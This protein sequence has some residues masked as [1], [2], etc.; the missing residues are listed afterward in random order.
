MDIC[1]KFL[2][3]S[4]PLLPQED[5]LIWFAE[6]DG[7]FIVKSAYHFITYLFNELV[8]QQASSSKVSTWD[9]VPLQVW[10][11]IWSCEIYPKIRNFLWRVCANGLATGDALHQS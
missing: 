7:K 1:R 8:Q 4:I 2:L 6:K 3:I 10:S 5:R 11:R 9:M